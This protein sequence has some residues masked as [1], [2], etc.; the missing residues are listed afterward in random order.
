[1]RKGRDTRAI[2]FSRWQR[3]GSNFIALPVSRSQH[4]PSQHRGKTSAHARALKMAENLNPTLENQKHGFKK[5]KVSKKTKG[6]FGGRLGQTIIF[7]PLMLKMNKEAFTKPKTLYF[8]THP[9]RTSY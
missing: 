2:F 6:K 7:R 9:S 8:S 5:I 4:S 1:M 3:N